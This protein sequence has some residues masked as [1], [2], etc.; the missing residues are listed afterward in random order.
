MRLIAR[1]A[2]VFT[3]LAQ[4]NDH[5]KQALAFGGEDILAIGAAIR[6]WHRFHDAQVDQAFETLREDVLRQAKAFLEITE[7]PDSAYRI[8]H[9]KE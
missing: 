6:R 8:P 7:A 4:R 9:D 5:R 1:K 2:C 3:P